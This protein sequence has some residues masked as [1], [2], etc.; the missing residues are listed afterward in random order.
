[1][2][3]AQ[4]ERLAIVQQNTAS[5]ALLAR[6]LKDYYNSKIKGK[7]TI[8]VRADTE[9]EL[10]SILRHFIVQSYQQQANKVNDKFKALRY[11]DLGQADHSAIDNALRIIEDKFYFRIGEI[12][13]RN[14]GLE[15]G[16]ITNISVSV[17]GNITEKQRLDPYVYI[18]G[19]ASGIIFG[20]VNLASKTVPPI[21]ITKLQGTNPDKADQINNNWIWKYLTKG[22]NLV[23]DNWER[24]CRPLHN[25]E[26]E[27]LDPNTPNP[28]FDRHIHCRCT[29]VLIKKR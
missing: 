19:I 28:P 25:R 4:R 23:C 20:G 14:Q 27:M 3:S 1:M 11:Y 9:T 10:D 7:P 8:N 21:I 12:E 26:F 6:I 13:D 5:S 18:N 22:D 2:S 17:G 29:M 16:D 15:F 24:A